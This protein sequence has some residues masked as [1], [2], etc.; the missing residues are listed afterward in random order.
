MVKNCNCLE[1]NRNLN[2][3]YEALK[4]LENYGNRLLLRF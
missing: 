4:L 3:S 1:R 2:I